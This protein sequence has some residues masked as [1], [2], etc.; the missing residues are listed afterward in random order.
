VVHGGDG[1]V[2]TG[3]RSGPRD[4]SLSCAV[5][6]FNRLMLLPLRHQAP[7]LFRPT[8][9]RVSEVCLVSQGRLFVQSIYS[10]GEDS[11]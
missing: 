10:L 11:V 7:P 1:L 3:P 2:I 4:S 5:C 6:I 8:S 9:S